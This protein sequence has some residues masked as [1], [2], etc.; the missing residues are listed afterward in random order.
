MSLLHN[1]KQL[2]VL[3]KETFPAT[4]LTL[5]YGSGAFAQSG[6]SKGKMLDILFA[7]DDPMKWH[8][9][10]I[11]TNPDHYSFAR[12]LSTSNLYRIQRAAAGV[13]Y[14]PFIKLQGLDSLIKYGVISVASLKKDLEEWSTIYVSGRMHKPVLL[15]DICPELN[16]ASSLNLSSAIRTA[17]LMLP[18]TFNLK[19]LFRSITGISY[20]GDIRMGIAEDSNKVDNIVT[21]NYSAFKQL[22]DSKLYGTFNHCIH[23]NTDDDVIQ[24]KSIHR[25][26]LHISRLPLTLLHRL[27]SKIGWAQVYYRTLKLEDFVQT[28]SDKNVENLSD[29]IALSLEEIIAITSVSQSAKGIL[30][31]GLWKSVIYSYEKVKKGFGIT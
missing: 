20:K 23:I 1:S 22:Y 12:Y 18:E 26:K 25:T 8:T 5:I 11:I 19:D 14:N 9:E 16:T 21:A 10:N 6:R 29:G 27:A 15:M 7:V 4:K 30:T 28:I 17:L 31:A 3:L 13:Y 2:L 24:D